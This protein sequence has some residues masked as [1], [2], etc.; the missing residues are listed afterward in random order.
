LMKLENI[1]MIACMM[2]SISSVAYFSMFYTWT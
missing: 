1:A 2:F